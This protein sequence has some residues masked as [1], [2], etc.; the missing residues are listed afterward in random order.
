MYIYEVNDLMFLIKSNTP[1]EIFNIK[2]FISFN[3]SNTRSGSHLKLCHPRVLSTY[4][5]YFYFNRIVGLWNHMPVIDISLPT[6]IKSETSQNIY[7][8][9]SQLT[10]ILTILVQPHQT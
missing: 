1:T 8:I 3:T 7:G 5:H 2:D 6:H 10:P 9:I 4:H